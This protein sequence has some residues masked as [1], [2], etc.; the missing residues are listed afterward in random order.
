VDN[1]LR[2]RVKARIGDRIQPVAKLGVEIIK[3][4]E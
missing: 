2:G 4:A 3:I 1:A